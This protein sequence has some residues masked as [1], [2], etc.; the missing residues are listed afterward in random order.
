MRLTSYTKYEKKKRRKKSLNCTAVEKR[1][2]RST[3]CRAFVFESYSLGRTRDRFHEVEERGRAEI[4]SVRERKSP[5]SEN[6]SRELGWLAERSARE[7][8]RA[9]RSRRRGLYEPRS[10]EKAASG[11]IAG[12]KRGDGGENRLKEARRE[13]A[14]SEG[15]RIPWLCIVMYTYIDIG[16]EAFERREGS[17][18]Q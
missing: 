15:S 13:D 6:K 17:R 10:R 2:S 8:E 11:R 4:G 1:S 5:S 18:F 9:G 12:K 3:Y 14:R 7:S 16:S